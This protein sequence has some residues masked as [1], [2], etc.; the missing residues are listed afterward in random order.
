MMM[1]SKIH[2]YGA[3][4]YSIAV[5]C[6]G[7][8]ALWFGASFNTTTASSSKTVNAAPAATFA[9]TGVGAIPDNAPGTP[10][11]VTFN[12]TGISGAPTNVEVSHTYGPNHTWVG[13]INCWLIAPNGTSFVIYG[14]TGQ[15]G[16]SAGDSSDLSGPYN[17]KDSAAGT[18]WWTAANTA[19]AAVVVPPGDYRTTQTGPQPVI[20]TSPVTNLSAAFSGVSN[21][22]GT[23]TLRFT[24]NGGGDTGS[25]SAAT[26]TIAGASAPLGR[27]FALGAPAHRSKPA[28]HRRD[29]AVR[30]YFLP[31]ATPLGL[32]FTC[33]AH[34]GRLG[35]VYVRKH[36]GGMEDGRYGSG[37]TGDL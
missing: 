1:R 22:N 31:R 4:M 18:N 17:F 9:G 5:L 33:P 23:W 34:R 3:L 24:D 8:V 12:V 29:F 10:L 7:A 28:S 36:K 2:E 37:E 20:T 16:A 21:P 13:D 11:N 35:P 30:G 27:S 6:A 15:T 14:R 25:I 32:R 26:L 19:G